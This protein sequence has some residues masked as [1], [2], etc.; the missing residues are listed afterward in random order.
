[1]EYYHPTVHYLFSDDDTDL[2]TEAA[3]LALDS[4]NTSREKVSR[5]R[6][7]PLGGEGEAYEEDEMEGGPS[8]SKKP[9][10][11]PPLMP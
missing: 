7:E 5:P 6:H 2:V 8:S 9:S 4:N 1:L 11:L 3:F 10:L